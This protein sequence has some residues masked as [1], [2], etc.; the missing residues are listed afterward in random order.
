[1]IPRGPFQPLLFYASVLLSLQTCCRD[2]AFVQG[3][4]YSLNTLNEIDY[5]QVPF[6]LRAE[7][8]TA[9]IK[10]KQTEA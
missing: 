10:T 9:L 2:V 3:C 4:N 1:M 8:Y 7:N 5:S 6:K